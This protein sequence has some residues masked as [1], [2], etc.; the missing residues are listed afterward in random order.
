MTDKVSSSGD[1]GGF[2]WVNL[3]IQVVKAIGVIL[4]EKLDKKKIECID[5]LGRHF[6]SNLSLTGAGRTPHFKE[7]AYNAFHVCYFEYPSGPIT[8]H[9]CQI[10]V[11]SPFNWRS[12]LHHGNSA[13]DARRQCEHELHQKLDHDYPGGP[14]SNPPT[15]S[16][17][18]IQ[19]DFR[20][21][22]NEHQHRVNKHQDLKDLVIKILEEDAQI[23]EI[24]N[25]IKTFKQSHDGLFKNHH[26]LRDLIDKWVK[27]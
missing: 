13:K 5:S 23:T 16:I 1:S 22:Q 25:A 27:E 19:K 2:D 20:A 6:I 11:V 18:M 4:E 10:E 3:G 15:N 12:N 9:D 26:E 7:R 21:Y 8:A 17:E 14:P 24:Q